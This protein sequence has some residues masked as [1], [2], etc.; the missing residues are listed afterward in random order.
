MHSIDHQFIQF[1]MTS[2]KKDIFS[3][4]CTVLP[5]Y[6]DKL[7]SLSQ[8]KNLMITPLKMLRRKIVIN[9]FN[10]T[11]FASFNSWW[12]LWK[13]ISSVWFCP[14][15]NFLVLLKHYFSG[16]WQKLPKYHA[17]YFVQNDTL[18]GNTHCTTCT[19]LVLHR[20]YLIFE[21]VQQN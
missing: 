16:T 20:T 1:M 3:L 9:A 4:I 17:T 21:Q 18:C 11:S 12:L 13:R 15:M 14:K 19:L 6:S 2:L 5:K 8:L 10:R 7:V